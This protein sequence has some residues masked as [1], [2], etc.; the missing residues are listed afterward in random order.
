MKLSEWLKENGLSQAKFAKQIG[1][2]PSIISRIIT[3]NRRAHAD[4]I[5][6]IRDAT[7]GEVGLDDWGNYR[8]I[9]RE[10]KSRERRVSSSMA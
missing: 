3:G 9:P 6:R 7:D 5:I 2:Q 8:E 10:K 1:I 4:L